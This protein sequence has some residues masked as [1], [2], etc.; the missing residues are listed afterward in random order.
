ML[1][2]LSDA[3]SDEWY[4]LPTVQ[5]LAMND[6]REDR[7]WFHLKEPKWGNTLTTI[8]SSSYLLAWLIWWLPAAFNHQTQKFVVWPRGQMNPELSAP[9][10]QNIHLSTQH[11]SLCCSPHRCGGVHTQFDSLKESEESNPSSHQSSNYISQCSTKCIFFFFFFLF[12]TSS[13]F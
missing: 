4:V 10:L 13:T 12:C 1:N 8:S 3:W 11:L 5:P 2:G 7:T 6:A 9:P